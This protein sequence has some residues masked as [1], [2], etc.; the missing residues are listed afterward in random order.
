MTKKTHVK[1]VLKYSLIKAFTKGYIDGDTALRLADAIKFEF[2]K[3]FPATHLARA[4]MSSYVSITIRLYSKS[5]KEVYKQKY[6][7]NGILPKSFLHAIEIVVEHEIAH[8]INNIGGGSGHDAG[9]KRIAFN[10]FNHTEV[11]GRKNERSIQD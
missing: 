8:I 3:K 7:I 1:N 5:I 10:L 4:S 11:V 6:L 9:F 2:S